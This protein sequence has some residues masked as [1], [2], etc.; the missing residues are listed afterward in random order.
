MRRTKTKESCFNTLCSALPLSL[1]H[2]WVPNLMLWFGC[3]NKSATWLPLPQPGCG[4]EWKETGKNWWVGWDKGS[5]T[6][7]QTKG[8]RTTMIQIRRIHNTKQCNTESR[9]HLPPLPRAPEPQESSCR[10][11]PPPELSMTTQGMEYPALFGQVGSGRPAVSL[12]GLR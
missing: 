5:L 6:E 2:A 11:A 12:P 3:R 7:Q 4:G 1:P 9:S 8:T 10:P